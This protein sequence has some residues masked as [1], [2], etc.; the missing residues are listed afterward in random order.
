MASNQ[1]NFISRSQ[2]QAYRWRAFCVE[3]LYGTLAIAWHLL[4]LA[5][6]AR[7]AKPTT[8]RWNAWSRRAHA[9]SRPGTM[10]PNCSATGHVQ[11]PP[12]R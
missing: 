7:R 9:Q 3:F 10:C 8:W 1:S 6:A 12:R 2:L 5:A 4:S 11:Q